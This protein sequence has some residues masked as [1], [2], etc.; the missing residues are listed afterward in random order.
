MFR[1]HFRMLENN[2][3]NEDEDYNNNN[4]NTQDYENFIILYDRI[5]TSKIPVVITEPEYPFRII[6]INE[7]WKELSGYSMEELYQRSIYYVRV[8]K[9]NDLIIN[10][11]KNGILFEHE[12]EV[13]DIP[14][15]NLKI[16]ITKK[17]KEINLN[18]YHL[19]NKYIYNDLR[20]KSLC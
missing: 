7:A 20:I 14:S 6:Y 15:L 18:Q 19:L 2:S 17:I 12:F 3:S 9:L 4:D 10:K 13:T 16:G 8:M 5:H 1:F 11:K